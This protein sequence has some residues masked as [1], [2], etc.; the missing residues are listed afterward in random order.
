MVGVVELNFEEVLFECECLIIGFVLFVMCECELIFEY[1]N[2]FV[3]IWNFDVMMC[4][5][6]D[7]IDVVCIEGCLGY[8][9]V[10]WCILVKY[11][12]YWFVVWLYCVVYIDCLLVN[13]LVDCF[14]LFICC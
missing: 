5:I 8:K 13:V 7:M 4:N 14:E 10:L 11:V 2:G 6:V 9:C 1:G 3:F 12:G